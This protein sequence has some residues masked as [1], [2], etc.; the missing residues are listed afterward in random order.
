MI[1]RLILASASPS[2]ASLLA[3]AGLDVRVEPASVDEDAI[4][5]ACRA[6]GGSASECATALAEAK[7]R[8][9]ASRHD[10]A[11]VIGADQLL[12]CDGQWFDKPLDLVS[13]R[14]Q[15]QALRGRMHELVTSVCVVQNRTRIWHTVSRPR[16]LMCEF[17]DAFLDD[18]LAAEGTAV[19]G[20]V[21]AYRLEERGVQLF[22]HIDGD[23]YSILGLPLLELLRF[24]RDRGEIL[25]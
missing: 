7:A 23:F 19:C 3:K 14:A 15:L 1:E 4:K 24:L 11:L 5:Q 16:L 8:R 10:G 25:L 22:E 20:S 9:I 21:G 18:Y 6:A 2:R 13:A 17:G 12:V